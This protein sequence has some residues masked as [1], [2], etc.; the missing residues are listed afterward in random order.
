M[1]MMVEYLKDG[2]STATTKYKIDKER[3]NFKNNHEAE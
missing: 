1:E 2:K 3:A